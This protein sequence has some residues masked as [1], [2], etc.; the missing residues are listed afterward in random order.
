MP[1]FEKASFRWLALQGDI[2]SISVLSESGYGDTIIA[3]VQFKRTPFGAWVNYICSSIKRADAEAFGKKE[4]FFPRGTPFRG[5]GLALTLLHS[6][7][8]LQCCNGHAPTLFIRVKVGL[9]LY[10]Y[11]LSLGFSVSQMHSKNLD[12]FAFTAFQAEMQPITTPG[13]H[14]QK[15]PDY[16]V[17]ECKKNVCYSTEQQWKPTIFHSADY[18]HKNK[19]G[20]LST[21]PDDYVLFYFPFETNGKF[22]DQCA[23]GLSMLGSPL[24]YFQNQLGL[25]TSTNLDL[26]RTIITGAKFKSME[27]VHVGNSQAYLTEEHVQF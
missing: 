18:H 19:P 8:L 6:V 17:L 15:D 16:V 23:R 21:W 2:L 9:Q 7:Q 3:A 5:M 10:A 22:I 14:W 24:L 4:P 25:A 1:Q 11:L 20:G 27:A 13:F 12:E 26:L